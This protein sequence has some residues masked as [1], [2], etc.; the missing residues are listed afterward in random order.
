M[1]DMNDI[2]EAHPTE[3]YWLILFILS[4]VLLYAQ[5]IF[6]FRTIFIP[7]SW[8]IFLT[9]FSLLMALAGIAGSRC[10]R[11]G[12]IEALKK[13]DRVLGEDDM[14]HQKHP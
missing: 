14:A 6:L 8:L 3:S 9:F 5:S 13:V 7:L 2:S 10:A 11:K 12:N 1:K 4:W